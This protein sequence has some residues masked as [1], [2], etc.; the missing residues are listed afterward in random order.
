LR[1]SAYGIAVENQESRNVSVNNITANSL[2]SILTDSYFGPSAGVFQGPINNVSASSV[3]QAYDFEAMV[4]AAP[5]VINNTYIEAAVRIGNFTNTLQYPNSVI[6]QG[7]LFD[8]TASGQF[9]A[10]YIT[11][12]GPAIFSGTSLN[13]NARIGNWSIGGGSLKFENGGAWQCARDPSPS[14][15]QILAINYS[16]GCL[17]GTPRFVANAS[18]SVNALDM[19]DPVTVSYITGGRVASRPMWNV[20]SPYGGYARLPM[21]QAMRQYRDEAGG[22]RNAVLPPESYFYWTDTRVVG[23]PAALTNDVLTFGICS[24]FQAASPVLP[25]DMI[26]DYTGTIFV[27][28]SVGSP[29]A[30]SSCGSPSTSVLVTARQQNNLN[31]TPG[32]NT[33]ASNNITTASLGS[34]IRAPAILISGPQV[35]I[36]TTLYYGDFTSGSATISGVSR[37]DGH[38]GDLASGFGAGDPF[39]GAGSATRA[40]C[41]VYGASGCVSWPIPTGAVT[42]STV[43][44]GNPGSI[45][46]SAPARSTGTFPVFPFELRP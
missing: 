3:Y 1:D 12:T 23:T 42:L 35:E 22:L 10:S 46:M 8:F 33:F 30:N 36:P 7:G 15:S 21:T 20:I 43:T 2:N 25:G 26:Y 4:Y 39:Y 31:V 11:N 41:T 5:L 37:G 40:A 28:N 38:G 32:T 24:R 14:A 6:F 17:A 9:P 18:G 34:D 44:P 29:T 27:I 45:V 13:A 19:T 16:G